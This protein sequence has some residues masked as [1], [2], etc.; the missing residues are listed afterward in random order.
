MAESSL[1]EILGILI[2]FAGIMLVLSL[3]VTALTQTTIGL[4]NIRWANLRVGLEKL[5]SS[6]LQEGTGAALARAKNECDAKHVAEVQASTR[7]DSL[8]K[9]K[10]ETADAEANLAAAKL[11]HDE[12]KK[13]LAAR[14]AEH[15]TG[16]TAKGKYD[17]RENPPEGLGFGSV[18]D[19]KGFLGSGSST[20]Q[21]LTDT[22]LPTAPS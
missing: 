3:L 4:M 21:T 22:R 11:A 17:P 10:K 8:K 5:L 1:F 9:D 6:A 20:G 7:L 15:E 14:T 16:E 12:A 2:G 13:K 18:Y 19:R